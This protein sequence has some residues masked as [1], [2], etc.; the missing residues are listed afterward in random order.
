[1][2]AKWIKL[3]TEVFGKG[4]DTVLRGDS[5]DPRLVALV[6]A[7]L[8]TEVPDPGG[9]PPTVP[10]STAGSPGGALA[11][12]VELA[13]AIAALPPIPTAAQLVADPALKA[14]FGR[15]SVT[16]E[17]FGAKGDG[18]TDDTAA[19]NTAIQACSAN[20]GGVV[21]L[22]PRAYAIGAPITPASGVRLHGPGARLR[23][24]SGGAIITGTTAFTRF[25]V[26]GITFSG[27]VNEYPTTPKRARSTSATGASAAIYLSGDLDITGTGQGIMRDFTM[28]NCRVE[29]C[30][31]LPINIRGVRGT[32]RVEDCTFYNNQDVGFI[33]DEEVIFVGNHVEMSA[34]NGVSLSR[35]N[36]KITCVGN[37]FE[38]V[39]YHGIWVAG[40]GTDLGP[41]EFT[42]TGNAVRD[43]GYNGIHLDAA[44]AHGTVVGNTV[45]G[46]YFRGPTDAPT[47][48]YG[49][50]IWIGGYPTTVRNAPSTVA[51]GI[52]VAANQIRN[53]ARIGIYV[54]GVYGAL[55]DGNLIKDVGTQYLADGT[56]AIAASD[57]T[58]NIGVLFDVP[59][60]STTVAIRDNIILDTRSTPY[61]NFG[62]VPQ[63]PTTGLG[64]IYSGNYMRGLRNGF[65]LQE[66]GQTQQV[67]Y[68]VQFL[69]GAVVRSKL[70]T[71]GPAPTIAAGSQAASAGAASNGATDIA[72][73]VNATSVAAPAAGTV[74][75]VTFATAHTN[76][77]RVL[78]LPRDA[79]TAN[80]RPYAGS[81]STTG[82]TIATATPPAASAALSFEYLVL[83]S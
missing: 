71:S 79:V 64:H 6:N 56:T 28:R 46:G 2:T 5:A 74:A 9:T 67:N 61:S 10:T 53:T 34:D 26:E 32:V 44:P 48:A 41:S 35:G 59:S 60:V 51:T 37:T 52:V 25:T 73:T 15:G 3:R 17:Q 20:G 58:Q 31:S 7:G 66:V 68:Q 36:R 33:F 12:D 29:N 54:T 24:L 63:I 40:F 49:A 70:T 81:P 80:T 43:V 75:T 1:M 65:N 23:K 76:V 30:T 83:A 42:V 8:A 72:G 77:P 78:V 14:A 82:F 21:H 50:G 19:I 18:T 55:I 27:T 69:S 16:P 62:V 22:A 4:K 47:D 13:A 45:T 39:A 38:N 11:T 57:A